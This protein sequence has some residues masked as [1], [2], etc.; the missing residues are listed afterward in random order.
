MAKQTYTT[1]PPVNEPDINVNDE[2]VK[3]QVKGPEHPVEDKVQVNE[4]H[5]NVDRVITDPSDPLAVI[6]PPEGRGDATNPIQAAYTDAQHPED[7]LAAA[8][9]DAETEHAETADDT[10]SAE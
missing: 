10:P 4:V 9:A 6:I 3:A 5:V 1:E 8:E 7:A 2:P